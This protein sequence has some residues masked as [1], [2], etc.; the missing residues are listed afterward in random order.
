[1]SEP[2]NEHVVFQGDWHRDQELEALRLDLANAQSTRAAAEENLARL[3]A[4][5]LRMTGE[6]AGLEAQREGLQRELKD[7]NDERNDAERAFKASMIVTAYLASL[8]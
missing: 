5:V 6:I 2:H 3:H 1:M 7:A 8:L 4:E